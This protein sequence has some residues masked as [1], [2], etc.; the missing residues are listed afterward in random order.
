[1]AYGE[2][3]DIFNLADNLS[4]LYFENRDFCGGEKFLQSIKDACHPETDGD[5]HP[6]S[7]LNL[8]H[9]ITS[10]HLMELIGCTTN[11]AD[12]YQKF[13]IHVDED[14]IYE[15]TLNLGKQLGMLVAFTFD[16]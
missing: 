16:V 6:C 13:D 2:L 9:N 14:L 15:Q 10:K 3:Q 4:N 11:L 1:M 12:S 5:E 8:F 7:G